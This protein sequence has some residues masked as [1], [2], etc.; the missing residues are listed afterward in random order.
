LELF[1]SSLNA[2]TKL[3]GLIEILSSASEFESIPIRHGEE[4]ILRKLALHLPLKIDKQ[5][6]TNSNTKVNVL[7]QAHFSRRSLSADLAADQSFILENSV[8][9]LQAMVDVVSS[10][11][12]LSPALAAMELSQMIT[13]AMWDKDPP[14]KQL[15][16]FDDN[17]VKRCTEKKVETIFE[18]MELE[19]DVRTNLLQMNDRSLQ[20]VARACNRYP[21]I[22]VNFEVDSSDNITSGS[23]VTVN[24]QLQREWEDEELPPVYA[25]LFPNKKQEGWWLVVGDP[26]ANMLYSIKRLTLQQKSKMK[27]TFAAPSAGTHNL[28]LYFMCDS[29]SGCDQEYEIALDVKPG[30]KSEDKMED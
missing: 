16:H 4:A 7:L 10:S 17:L 23:T 5:V 20:D 28:T 9:L 29:Y 2:K 24:V 30:Q 25:S 1:D 8:R 12:W 18:L 11:S 6:Y 27:L 14:L 13:Q 22:E 15:P 3:K 26:K 21:N 19:D